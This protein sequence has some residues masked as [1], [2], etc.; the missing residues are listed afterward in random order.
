MSEAKDIIVRHIFRVREYLSQFQEMLCKRGLEHD[1]NKLDKEELPFFEKYAP[2]LKT[3]K[4][5]SDEY[6]KFLE[7]LSPALKHHYKNNR[8]HPEH[9]KRYVCN[10][11]FEIYYE[12]FGRCKKCGYTQRQTETDISQMNLIDIVEMLCDWIAA[13]EQHED[14]G[15]ISKSIEIN[16]KRF[17]Y[18]DEVKQILLN[19]GNLFK[20]DSEK[21]L[22]KLEL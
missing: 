16:Q 3:C 15:D 9:F 11:C 6:K 12:E 19:T 5:G 1:L 13:G 14:G 4:Y 10:G 8:H 22:N 2:L 7:E 21:V 18:S 20:K 17:G